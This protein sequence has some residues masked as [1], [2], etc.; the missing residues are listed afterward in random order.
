M[1]F[2]LVPF[3][4]VV[5]GLVLSYGLLDLICTAF[6]ILNASILFAS[7]GMDEEEAKELFGVPEEFGGGF[8]FTVLS[9]SDYWYVVPAVAWIV[10]RA[11]A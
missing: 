10:Y 9:W 8:D 11:L 7:G 4:N 6:T 1:S 2:D 3:L 5:A